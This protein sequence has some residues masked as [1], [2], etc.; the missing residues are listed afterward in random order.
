MQIDIEASPS[1]GTA[2]VK[3]D[4]GDKMV[5]E[6]G[7][8]VAMSPKIA[9]ETKFNGTGSGGI[10][11]WILAAFTG[12][13]RKFLAGE[14]MFVNHYRAFDD[15]QEVML[16]PSMIG[17]VAH[18]PMEKGK[19]ITVQA[20]SYL[21]SS[22]KVMV[23]LVWG[24]LSM[25]FGGEGAFFLKCFGE[26]DLL[27]NSYGGIEKVPVNGAYVVD[28]GHVVAWEGKLTHRIKKAGGW[29][30]AMLSG[31]GL[32]IEFNGEGTVWMQTRNVGA[33][34]GWLTPLLPR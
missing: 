8:M 28:S 22:P 25:L 6:S 12:L 20:T 29:K 4:K 5:A 13:V 24:G 11:D 21:A 3:L 32:V 10:I 15:A 7:A 27:I 26:G 14:T 19:P 18:V 23:K 31:E 2:I 30:S 34:V 17:D 16:A 1:Y 33:L 9:V